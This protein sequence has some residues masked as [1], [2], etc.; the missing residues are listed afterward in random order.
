MLLRPS[1]S[2]HWHPWK[3]LFDRCDAGGGLLSVDYTLLSYLIVDI[4]DD[5]DR[6][7]QCS[8]ASA[9]RKR[10]ALQQPEAPRASCVFVGL[11]RDRPFRSGSHRIG[12][13]RLTVD[14]YVLPEGQGK[15]F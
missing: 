10:P 12:D 5:F 9:M 8:P 3:L 2:L 1:A 13:C 7:R 14:L 6:D 11:Q 4:V 15:V